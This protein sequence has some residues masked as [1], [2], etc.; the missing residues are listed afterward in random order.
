MNIRFV[1]VFLSL[2]LLS[3]GEETPQD[4]K[5]RLGDLKSEKAE[6]EERIAELERALEESDDPA[7]EV[8]SDKKPVTLQTL[9]KG[10]FS[11]FVEVQGEAFTRQNAMIHPEANGVVRE[12]YPEEGEWVE[13]GETIMQVDD[14][15]IRNNIEEVTTNLEHSRDLYRRQ[16]NL[17]DK[18]IGSEVEYL[19]AKN[20][21]ERLEKNLQSLQTQ[22]DQHQLEAPFSGYLDELHI[23]EGE[24]AN[25]QQPAARIINPREM[26][27]RA[28]VSE[29]YR[30]RVGGLDSAKVRIPAIDHHSRLPIAHI[31]QLIDPGDRTFKVTLRKDNPDER[32]KPNMLASIKLRDYHRDSV[33][34]VP[35]DVIKH[36]HDRKYV[37]LAENRDGDL[38]A[39]ERTVETGKSQ[40][41]LTEISS[42]LEEGDKLIVRGHANVSEGDKLNPME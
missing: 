28:R 16:K 7:A 18:E 10:E 31:G 24:L 21:V 22:L 9:E 26:R 41:R 11:H 12:I 1:V 30:H 17:W 14:E 42:G 15:V 4:K 40:D 25:P 33:I 23:E 8:P 20:E 39:T 37:Y 27:L 35:V 34:S 29:E 6:I 19:R 2:L 38:R 5:E 3:C 32:L 13:E 36:E